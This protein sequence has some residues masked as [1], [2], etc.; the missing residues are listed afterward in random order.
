MGALYQLF[1]DQFKCLPSGAVRI[2]GPFDTYGVIIKKQDNG[3]WLIRGTGRQE[4]KS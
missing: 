3:T 2:D 4:Q 1:G